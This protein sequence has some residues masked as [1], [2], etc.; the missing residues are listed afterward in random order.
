MNIGGAI[1]FSGIPLILGVYLIIESMTFGQ[2]R[3]KCFITK[4]AHILDRT[5]SCIKADANCGNTAKSFMSNIVELVEGKNQETSTDKLHFYPGL[6]LVFIGC[7]NMIILFLSPT[8]HNM[9]IVPTQC[10]LLV[11]L[12]VLLLVDILIDVLGIGD[13]SLCFP[14]ID[15]S[16]ENYQI[17]TLIVY[18]T[19]IIFTI[20]AP[21]FI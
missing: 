14:N 15:P 12:L 20:Y 7:I 6:V 11:L 3:T 18:I 13:I 2:W 1:F 19:S 21:A 16:F 9:L 17:V 8:V 5:A 4:L 10:S